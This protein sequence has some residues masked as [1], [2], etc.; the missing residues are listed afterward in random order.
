MATV[1][2]QRQLTLGWVVWRDHSLEMS[3]L[4]LQYGMFVAGSSP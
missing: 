2:A 4:V 1:V 3:G